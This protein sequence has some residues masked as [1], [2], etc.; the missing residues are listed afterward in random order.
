MTRDSRWALLPAL[1]AALW[2]TMMASGT[3]WLDR[4]VL[5]T[6]YAGDRPVMRTAAIAVTRLGEWPVVV[7]VTIA[8]GAALLSR[9]APRQA[10]LFVA[11]VLVGRVLV[12]LQKIGIARLRPEERAYLVAVNSKSFPS[13][14]AGNSMILLLAVA[15][16][17]VP[18]RHRPLAIAIAVMLSMLIGITRPMLGVHWPSDVIGGWSFGAAWVLTMAGLAERWPFERSRPPP[19]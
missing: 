10:L 6:V 8:I 17:V 4:L 11:I 16:V 19:G 14:H 9:R 2:L 3:G 12:E 15:M 7:A 18:A 1:L 13:G 5:D